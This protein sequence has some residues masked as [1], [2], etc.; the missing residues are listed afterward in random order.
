MEIILYIIAAFMAIGFVFLIIEYP[1]HLVGLYI[2]IIHYDY[3]LDLPGPLD[4]RGILT[5]AFFLRLIAFDKENLNLFMHDFLKNPLFLSVLFFGLYFVMVTYINT[6]SFMRTMRVEIFQLIGLMIGFLTVYKGYAKKALLTAIIFAGIFSTGDLIYSYLTSSGSFYNT[7]ILDV[8]TKS[9]FNA[10]FNHNVMGMFIGIGIVATFMFYITKQMN[11]LLAFIIF[12][13]L[14]VGILISTSRGT[15]LAVIVAIAIGVFMLPKEVVNIK[16]LI[17][18]S[19]KG[20]AFLV[21]IV[22]GYLFFI[23]AANLDSEFSKQLYYRLVEEP[24]QMLEGK[25]NDYTTSGALKEGTIEWRVF[26]A[27]R[28]IGVFTSQRLSTQLLGYGEGG[29][30]KIGKKEWSPGGKLNQYASHNG[31]V[32]IVIERGIIG[33]VFMIIIYLALIITSI[34]SFKKN[35]LT[36][37]FFAILIFYIVYSYGAQT[38]LIGKFAYVL[39]G[40]VIAQRILDNNEQEETEEEEVEEELQET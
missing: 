36:F 35:Y 30:F 1:Y 22:G 13:I 31:F 12:F 20:L 34:K 28:D 18:L 16:K 14:G 33:F 25:S 40:G 11:N 19:L 2:F 37:P 5:I 15:L 17:A 7:R 3:N 24:L 4:L 8:I 26:Q 32:L 10:F 27:K 39:F 6:N 29:Y 21:I 9:E 23:K 38:Q